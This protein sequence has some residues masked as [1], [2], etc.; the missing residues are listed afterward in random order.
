MYNGDWHTRLC[1]ALSS[2]RRE[3]RSPKLLSVISTLEHELAQ[4]DECTHTVVVSTAIPLGMDAAFLM[5][6][7]Q[8]CVGLEPLALSCAESGR[9][10]LTFTARGSES[11]VR[12][13]ARSILSEGVA[14]AEAALWI[15]VLAH[16]LG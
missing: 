13:A 14:K 2:A 16:A 12:L 10:E 8:S 15:K 4:L 1:A 5:K 3:T 9:I 6:S 7:I 11:F